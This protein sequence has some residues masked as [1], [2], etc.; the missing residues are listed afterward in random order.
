ML[1]STSSYTRKAPSITSSCSL[2]PGLDLPCK[3]RKSAVY[4]IAIIIAFILILGVGDELIQPAQTRVIESIYCRKY[5]DKVDPGLVGGDGWVDE[6]YCKGA[7][8]QGQVASLKA[9]AIALD[10]AGSK[11]MLLS[12]GVYRNTLGVMRSQ[13]R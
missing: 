5:Y 7:K 11:S 13:F 9:W 10:G 6:K 3:P 4:V 8:V 2:E 1:S 12:M